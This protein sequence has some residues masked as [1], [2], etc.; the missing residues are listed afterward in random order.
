VNLKVCD[1]C[2]QPLVN[3]RG[4]IVTVAERVPG[5]VE[6]Q[7]AHRETIKQFKGLEL[8]DDC[9][10]RITETLDNFI[11]EAKVGP[12]PVP[13][14]VPEAHRND[15]DMEVMTQDETGKTLY[16]PETETAADPEPT[17]GKRRS[18]PAAG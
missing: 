8:C 5:Q 10:G 13:G 3:P 12:S 4:I 18:S 15:D 7:R 2:K 11:A 6:G 14:P 16:L 9:P 1:F 17:R